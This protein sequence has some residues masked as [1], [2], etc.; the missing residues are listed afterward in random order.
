MTTDTHL[1]DDV[2]AGAL[3]RMPPSR[4][5]RLARRGIVPHIALP[6]GE[7]RFCAADLLAWAAQ[8][9]QPGQPPEAAQ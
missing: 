9:R 3:L 4:L 2:E 6:D 5:T 8:Y 7:L 1:L